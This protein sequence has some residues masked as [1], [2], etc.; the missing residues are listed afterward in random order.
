M[1]NGD[2]SKMPGHSLIQSSSDALIS[3][4]TESGVYHINSLAEKL[5]GWS[6]S[7][8]KGLPLAEIFDLL[9]EQSGEPAI[10]LVYQCL[11]KGRVAATIGRTLLRSRSGSKF[12]IRVSVVPYITPDGGVTG[13]AIVFKDISRERRMAQKIK[14]HATHDAL[15]GLVN[16]REFELR[17]E[18][19]LKGNQEHGGRY[20]LGYVDLDQFKT[21]NDTAGHAAGDRLLKQ[22]SSR[23]MGQLRDRDTLA[24]LGGDEFALLLD[25]CPL[26]QAIQIVRKLI[27][28]I[29]EFQFSSGE[30]TFQIGACVGLVEIDANKAESAAQL[31]RL[32]DSACYQAKKEGRN[33]VSIY[34]NDEMKHLQPCLSVNHVQKL[35][36]AI[37][38][39]QLRLYKNNP[40]RKSL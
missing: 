33:Q 19:A 11:I 5:T 27:C 23:L 36:E 7:E 32:A 40:P 21:V 20:V 37:D 14:H 6:K 39:N 8:A 31:L 38:N 12:P 35:Q 28:S 3:I 2:T 1:P 15:T 24:R 17:L 29:C 16:R 4:D 9:D 22:I 26:D 10:D 18:N 25:N 34:R 30:R 13:A